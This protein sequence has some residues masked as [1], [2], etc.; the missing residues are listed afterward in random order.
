[1]AR[2]FALN[3]YGQVS[4]AV[5]TAAPV[6]MGCWFR[7]T[8]AAAANLC[9]L[10]LSTSATQ[11]RMVLSINASL[12]VL[13]Q[14]ADTTVA[15]ATTSTAGST[16][17]WAH[18]CGVFASSTSRAAY[19]NG[20][21][22]GTNATSKVPAGMNRTH[23]GHPTAVSITGD[24]AEVA[25]WSAALT[26][27]EVAALATG[28]SPLWIQSASLIGYWPVWGIASPEIDL[29]PNNRT[30]ALTGSPAPANHAPVRPFTR[31]RASQGTPFWQ[32]PTGAGRPWPVR[33][34]QAPAVPDF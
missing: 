6:T 11:H 8:A 5:A 16:S 19:L 17:T 32:F 22:K 4:S 18:A 1:M 23:I 10:W 15:S 9:G 29:T 34:A 20:G 12:N 21:G 24:I 7:Q 13:A 14:T 2:T 25:M 31:S 28:I 27:A 33:V 30:M 26:D 3:V